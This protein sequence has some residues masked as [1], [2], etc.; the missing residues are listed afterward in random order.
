M[1]R[2]AERQG[3]PWSGHMAF[4]GG[5]HEPVDPDLRA[6]AMRETFEEVGLDLRDHVHLGQL[7]ELNATARGRLVGMTITPHVFAL[8]GASSPTLRPNY[9][10]AELVWG[11]LG[12]MFRGELDAIKEL[13][14]NGETRRLPAFQV[15]EHLV[16]GMTHNMLLSLFTLLGKEPAKAG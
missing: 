16:W 10:V 9:E 1:I 15:R 8:Q 3:D 14:Y 11:S 12:K 2:R 13:T 4:P 7:D 5:H 6:T